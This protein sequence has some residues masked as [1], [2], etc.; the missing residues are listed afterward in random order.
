MRYQLELN[1]VKW[2]KSMKMQIAMHCAPVL[3]GVKPSNAVALD[4][5][6]SSDLLEALRGTEIQCELIYADSDPLKCL[7]LLYRKEET[8][9]Y[10]MIKKHRK[11]LKACGYSSFQLKDILHT[12]KKRYHQYKNQQKDFPH[13][14]GLILGYPLCDVEGFIKHQGKKC[15]YSGYWKVYGNLSGTK[16]LFGIYDLVRYQMVKQVEY[17]KS[18]KQIMESY[19]NYRVP[20]YA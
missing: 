12:F 14:F 18:L 20:N 11:F 4:D 9:A 17:G 19:R 3:A 1:Q 2:E 6:D 13:E 5:N 15:L 7:W 8:E 10:L 16:K